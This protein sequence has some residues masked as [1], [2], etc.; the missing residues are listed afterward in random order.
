[1][2]G[3]EIKRFIR[4]NQYL[5]AAIVTPVVA[6][7]PFPLWCHTGGVRQTVRAHDEFAGAEHHVLVRHGKGHGRLVAA[8]AAVV[9][10]AD[11]LAVQAENVGIGCDGH[12]L[13]LGLVGHDDVGVPCRRHTVDFRDLG[14]G[15]G[16]IP[17]D[18]VAIWYVG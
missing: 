18:G 3:A 7:I 11:G 10:R 17:G 13:R 9:V 4:Q 5:G 6:D 2:G 14:I 16:F 12:N 1:M 8:V 15:V